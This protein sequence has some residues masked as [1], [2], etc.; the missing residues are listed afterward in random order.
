M[1][2]FD[3]LFKKLNIQPKNLELY[4]SAFTHKSISNENK[5]LNS[6]DMLEFLGDGI[7]QAKV[8]LYLYKNSEKILDKEGEATIIRAKIVGTDSFSKIAD[9]LE[10]PKYLIHSKSL[11]KN[12]IPNKIKADLF[13]SLIAAIY[14][15]LGDKGLDKVLNKFIYPKLDLIINKNGNNSNFKDSKSKFQEYIQSYSYTPIF[16]ETHWDTEKNEFFSVVKHDDK[17]YGSG[18]GKTK[19]AAEIN[20]ATS[21]L[22]KFKF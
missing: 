12:T 4:K 7:M 22:S 11:N 20:A 14:L 2:N 19:K 15:D 6:Y 1:K 8:S 9:I 21:A 5:T 10:L 3:E 16:Y 13:E 17:I 18:Y